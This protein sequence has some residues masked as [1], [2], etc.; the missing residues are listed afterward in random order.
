MKKRKIEIDSRDIEIEV[1]RKSKRYKKLRSLIIKIIIAIAIIYVFTSA[2]K[3]TVLENVTYTIK[4]PYTIQEPYEVTE[5]YEE[6]VP[7]GSCRMK[8][9]P[10]NYTVEMLEKT[11]GENNT[12]RCAL[13]LTNNENVSGTWIY[14]AYLTTDFG[15]VEAPMQTKEVQPQQSVIFSWDIEFTPGTKMIA[16]NIFV[17]SQPSMQKCFYPEP[18]TWTTKKKTRTVTKYRNITQYREVQITNETAVNKTVNRFF[19]YEQ[20]FDL[21]W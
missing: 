15:R 9:V 7:F 2:K 11:F 16:C 17:V 10:M 8:Y 20:S 14:D 4:E 18:I 21:G 1:K 19:G 12:V 13:K 6:K 3:V 5:E